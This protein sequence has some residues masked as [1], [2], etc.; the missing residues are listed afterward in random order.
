MLM[1]SLKRLHLSVDC[2]SLLKDDDLKLLASITSL[3]Q[4]SISM[5]YYY[6]LGN[7]VTDAGI[8]YLCKLPRLMKLKLAHCYRLTDAAL[9]SLV[10]HSVAS[11]LTELGLSGGGFSVAGLVRLS[12]HASSLRTLNLNNCRRITGPKR[13][14]T[15]AVERMTSLREISLDGTGVYP[16]QIAALSK[17]LGE[18]GSPDAEST[19][20]AM[21]VTGPAYAQDDYLPW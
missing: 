9:D 8:G 20:L 21:K 7:T 6:H 16:S 18:R 3:E 11:R 19:R 12:F 13:E 2:F 5:R 14:L 10:H 15:E 4:L 17:L 1:P